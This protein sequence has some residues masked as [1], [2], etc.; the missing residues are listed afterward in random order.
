MLLNILMSSYIFFAVIDSALTYI[1]I[2]HFGLVEIWPSK[3]LFQ[4]YGLS[5]GL[6]VGTAF[7]F[8]IGWLLWKMRGFK[9]AT[10]TAVSALAVIEF[11]AVVNNTILIIGA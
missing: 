5:L 10:Y 9:F 2:K 11:A 6:I 7:C 3:V 1:G 4:Y 8:F